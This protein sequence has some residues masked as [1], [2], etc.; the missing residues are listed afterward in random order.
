VSVGSSRPGV[1]AAALTSRPPVPRHQ[2]DP[3]VPGILIADMS[4]NFCSKPVDVSKYGVRVWP[5][6]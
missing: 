5:D 2:Q 1:S 3:V 4:S 6:T